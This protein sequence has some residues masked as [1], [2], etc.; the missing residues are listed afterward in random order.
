[1][2]ANFSEADLSDVKLEGTILTG[3][4]NLELHQIVKALGDRTTRLPDYIEVPTDW[5]QSS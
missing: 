4:K 3:G 2:G 5:R 1:M